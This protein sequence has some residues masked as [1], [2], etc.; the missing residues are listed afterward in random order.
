MHPALQLL[1]PVALLFP[2]MAVVDL[3]RDV[4][5]P[6]DPAAVPM[7]NQVSVTHRVTV[8]ISTRPVPMPMEPMEL[9]QQGGARFAERKMGK[10]LP[11]AEIAGIQ[12]VSNDRLLFILRD[13]RLVSV[14][15]E[16][17]CQARE[18]Y[19]GLILRRPEDGQLCVKRDEL[20]S[21]SGA[22]CRLSG[23]RQL[24]PMGN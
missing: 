13:D 2:A 7:A 9:D 21:R 12:P 8:R 14:Q 23:L 6:A 10:C 16:K 20:L 11:I 3:P 18:F 22:S 15:L 24:V 17:G 19:S 5:A 4:P 1:A